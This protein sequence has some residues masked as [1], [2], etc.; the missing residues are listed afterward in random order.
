MRSRLWPTAL[1]ALWPKSRSAL[2]LHTRMTPR[3]SAITTACVSI[4]RAKSRSGHSPRQ[5]PTVGRVEEVDPP[6]VDPELGGLP[7]A[8]ARRGVEAG[9]HLGLRRG[10]ELVGPRV[11]GQLVEVAG[12]GPLAPRREVP[13][14]P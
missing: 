14:H 1:A 7:L 13:G 8:R 9:H 10:A 2:S 4:W 12:D 6:G 5:A 3:E 11:A